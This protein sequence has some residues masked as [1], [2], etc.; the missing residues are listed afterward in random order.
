M[1]IFSLKTWEYM[2]GHP[3]HFIHIMDPL[4]ITHIPLGLCL[5]DTLI[6]LSWV[7]PPISLLYH[8]LSYVIICGGFRKW[9]YPQIIHIL[10]GCPLITIH[11]GVPPSMETPI[12]DNYIP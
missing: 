10:I 6:A 12:T 5:V 11:F 2:L 7:C 4:G 3:I 8:G 1:Y 9:W